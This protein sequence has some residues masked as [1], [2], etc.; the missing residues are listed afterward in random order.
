MFGVANFRY[1]LTDDITVLL[2]LIVV[3][4]YSEIGDRYMYALLVLL[5]GIIFLPLFSVHFS[6]LLERKNVCR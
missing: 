2:T 5:F 1:R 3:Y 6:R 4:M